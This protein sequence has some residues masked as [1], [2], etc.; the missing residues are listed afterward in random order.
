[1]APESQFLLILSP[2]V[3]ASSL[4]LTVCMFANWLEAAI[5]AMCSLVYV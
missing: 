1:M 2:A 3:P 5:G 4:K